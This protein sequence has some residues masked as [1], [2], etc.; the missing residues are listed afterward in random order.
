MDQEEIAHAALLL[1][2]TRYGVALTGAGIST[3]SGI[4]DFRGTTGLW[5]YPHVEEIATLQTFRTDPQRFYRWFHTLLDQLA[6]AQ[7][8]PAHLALAALERDGLLR[9][10]LTQNVDG[11]HQRA[12][13]REVYELHGHPRTATCLG[14]GRQIPSA[15]LLTSPRRKNVPHCTCGA[16]FKIDVVLFDELLPMGIL[17]LAQHEI[18]QCDTLLVIGTTLEVAPVCDMPLAALRHNAHLI[19]IN[20]SETFLDAHADVVIREDVVLALPAIADCL[21]TL[22]REKALGA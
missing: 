18:A 13:S 5:S 10:V 12:G 22:M 20:Q 7:P 19:I 15:P 3:P 9:A 8:N 16:P 4:P 6:R 14:C 11:L 21:S 17:R 2:R 1:C